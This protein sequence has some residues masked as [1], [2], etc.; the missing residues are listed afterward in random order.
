[1]A[2]TA[3]VGVRVAKSDI[4]TMT[5][6]PGRAGRTGLHSTH[7]SHTHQG[8]DSG[9]VG[10]PAGEKPLPPRLRQAQAAPDR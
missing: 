9:D 7:G 3:P 4:V 5:F 8:A 1:M 6:V 2:A 10:A